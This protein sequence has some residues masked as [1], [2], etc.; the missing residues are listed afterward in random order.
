MSIDTV[1][2]VNVIAAHWGGGLPFYALMPE[3]DEAMQRTFFDSAAT[4][5]LYRPDVYARAVD[6]VGA[7]RIL[8][9]SDF[10]LVSQ[11][12]QMKELRAAVPA[13]EQLEMILGGNAQRL[14]GGAP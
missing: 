7:E 8:F 1:P 6:L 9:G 10:P 14:L 12:E 5:F 4:G 11:A 3:V 13:A 2:G